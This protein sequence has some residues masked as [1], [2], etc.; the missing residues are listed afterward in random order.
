MTKKMGLIAHG[1]LKLSIAS[2]TRKMRYVVTHLCIY[3]S[4]HVLHIVTAHRST[5]N[6][7]YYPSS[8]LNEFGKRWRRNSLPTQHTRCG[9]IQARFPLR[10][11]QITR[12][13]PAPFTIRT[14]SC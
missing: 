10:T 7:T 14:P 12:R 2:L 13:V 6:S 8:T 1:P 9:C 11:T 3:V 4:V 5:A